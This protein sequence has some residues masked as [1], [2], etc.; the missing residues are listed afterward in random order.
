MSSAEDRLVPREFASWEDY[1]PV[2]NDAELWTPYFRRALEL[3]REAPADV[4]LLR[5]SQYPTARSGD[6]VVT[7]YPGPLLGSGAYA[8]EVEAHSLLAAHELPTPELIAHGEFR[9]PTGRA[10]WHWLVE[11]TAPGMPWN[12]LRYGLDAD[13]MRRGA[14]QTGAALR[15]FHG[16]P[17]ESGSILGPDWGRFLRLITDE[18]EHLGD[19]DERLSA[20]PERIRPALRALAA[21][22]LGAVDTAIPSS[23]LHG[24]VH[25]DNIF[26][27]PASGAVSAI[28]DFNEM[29]AGDPWYDLADACFRLLHGTPPLVGDLLRGYSLDPT[30]W[31]AVHLLAWGLLH[32]FDGL[33]ATVE[34]R[35]IPDGD[36]ISRLAVHLTG[37]GSWDPP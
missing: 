18:V 14:W 4:V 21:S 2:R 25:G 19:N 35:G 11:S 6:V 22:T 33:S 12:R 32:D 1:W 17:H 27:D 16:V 10:F 26:L 37:L 15:E 29:Y 36:D 3:A 23:L 34:H 24:D 7:V 13:R 9:D 8:M 28:I 5:P 20:F 31:V 30:P